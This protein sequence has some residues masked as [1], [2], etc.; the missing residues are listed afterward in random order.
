M[1]DKSARDIVEWLLDQEE[2]PVQSW[3]CFECLDVQA[4]SLG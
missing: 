1:D 2:I 4:E 3:R